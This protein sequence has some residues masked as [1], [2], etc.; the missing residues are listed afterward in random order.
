MTSLCHTATDTQAYS[1]PAHYYTV[2]R[3][4]TIIIPTQ[5]VSELPATFIEDICI[6]FTRT[7][8][9]AHLIL[10]SDHP[11]SIWWKKKTHQLSSFSLFIFFSTD[12][13]RHL[14]SNCSHLSTQTS[15]GSSTYLL[16]ILSEKFPNVYRSIF[17]YRKNW[18]WWCKEKLPS[19]HSVKCAQSSCV[20]EHC[21]VL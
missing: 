13:F 6:A 7:V 18:S 8:L 4:I 19:T 21:D 16:L 20:S 11:N 17:I 12:F 14:E 5:V 3:F 15:R 9:P 1:C 10:W 2:V